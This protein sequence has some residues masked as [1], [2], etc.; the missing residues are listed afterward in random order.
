M[1]EFAGTLLLTLVVVG[2]G[3]TTRRANPTL[4][5][6]AEALGVAG[7]LVGLIIAFGQVSGGHF[8]PLI[9]F[10]QWLSGLRDLNCTIAYV[11]AQVA[12]GIVGALTAAL[13]FGA[14]GPRSVAPFTKPGLAVSEFV[15]SA[16][17]MIIV[18]G[19]TRGG[20]TDAA[21]FAV[22]AWLAAAIMATPS[23]SYANPAIALAAIFAMGPASLP[24][25]TA[26]LYV[27]VQVVGA[28]LALATVN[29]CYPARSGE[30]PV[31]QAAGENDR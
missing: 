28:L 31:L 27:L 6:M 15:A 22:G 26:F 30:S 3:L 25:G 7:A 20:R 2:V 12:G 4:G 23:G 8:N 16:G 11:A 10:L 19:C 5:V 13:M 14:F 29:L 24:A 18:F 17:L 1:A 21:P 9:T